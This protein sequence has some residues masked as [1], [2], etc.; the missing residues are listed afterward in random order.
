MQYLEVWKRQPPSCVRERHHAA[1]RATLRYA[2]P[3]ATSKEQAAASAAWLRAAM[4][5]SGYGTLGNRPGG[6]A[7]LAQEADVNASNL[8][9]WLSGDT[10][11]SPDTLMRLA[12]ILGADI[13]EGLRACG[14]DEMA[15]LIVKRTGETPVVPPDPALARIE[16]ARGI[17]DSE[18]AFLTGFYHRRIEAARAEAVRELADLIALLERRA[19][20]S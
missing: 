8:S 13:I 20:V 16:R 19:E 3:M 17:G 2:A 18:R 9:R 1:T 14:Y 10:I 12:D 7:Q 11:P 5:A 6:R 4:E 15:A